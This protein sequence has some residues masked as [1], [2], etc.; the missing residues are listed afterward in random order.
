MTVT[1]NVALLGSTP[2]LHTNGSPVQVLDRYEHE[3][4]A[5]VRARAASGAGDHRTGCGEIRSVKLFRS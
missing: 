1:P 5:A 2:V 3:R 4:A